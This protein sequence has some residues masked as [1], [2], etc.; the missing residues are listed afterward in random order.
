MRELEHIGNG[1]SLPRFYKVLIDIVADLFIERFDHMHNF[2]SSPSCL[3]S[4]YSSQTA[5][6]SLCHKRQ[7][8]TELHRLELIILLI[9]IV[10][11]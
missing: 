9:S 3:E 5:L 10:R 11:G 1:R 4:S 7:Q 2:W 8:I 6:F